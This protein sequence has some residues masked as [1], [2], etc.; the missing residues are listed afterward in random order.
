M[1]LDHS[2]PW[3]VLTTVMNTI[4]Q[5]SYPGLQLFGVVPFNSVCQLQRMKKTPR[6][7]QNSFI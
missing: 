4:T 7:T 1:D 3:V 6:V 5:V 2:H